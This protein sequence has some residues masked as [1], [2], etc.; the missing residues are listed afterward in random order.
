MDESSSSSDSASD[1][2]PTNPSMWIIPGQYKW[3]VLRKRTQKAHIS[4]RVW[5]TEHLRKIKT[6]CGKPQG[7]PPTGAIPQVVE[8]W[9]PETHT[10]HMTQGEM[11]ITLQDVAGILGLPTDGTVVTGSTSED[12]HA[13]CAA[14]FGH[15]PEAGEFHRSSDLRISF[16][17]Q[18]YT[19]WTDQEGNHDAEIYFTK[20]HIARM[21]GTWLLADKSRD[22]RRTDMGGCHILLQIWAWIQFPPIALPLPPHPEPGTHYGCRFNTVEKFK[23]HEVTHYRATLDTLCRDEVVWQPYIEY[24]WL[25]VTLEQQYLW[26][27]AKPIIYFHTVEAC[28]PDRCMRQFDLDQ[29]IPDKSR[30]LRGIH[31]HTLRGKVEENWR[32]KLRPHIDRWNTKVQHIVLPPPLYGLMSPN[33]A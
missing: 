3:E 6:M 11:M 27:A 2:E 10:F 7:G 30:K 32:R 28:Q 20:A 33:H 15:V 22:A 14:V 16:L 17:D 25:D 5:N 1:V 21:L 29:P 18:H 26:L 12:W 9:R 31:D 24:E 19:W 13:A 8:E 4:Q 23:P